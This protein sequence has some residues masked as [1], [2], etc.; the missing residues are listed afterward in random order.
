MCYGE[1]VDLTPCICEKQKCFFVFV[2]GCRKIYFDVY[3]VSSGG[4]FGCCLSKELEN[5][6][7][8]EQDLELRQNVKSFGKRKLFC[9]NIILQ[10]EDC[11]FIFC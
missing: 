2:A 9:L 4:K 3:F 10:V 7:T 1:G 8:E 5:D 6:W 11:C